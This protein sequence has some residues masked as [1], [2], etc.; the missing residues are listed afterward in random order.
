[1]SN[2]LPSKTGLPNSIYIWFSS[3]KG[4]QHGPRIKVSN[5]RGKFSQS[6]DFSVSVSSNPKVVAGSPDNF[7]I[8][9]INLIFDWVILNK[10][11][12]LD[13][14]KSEIITDDDVKEKV[15]KV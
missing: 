6:S 13:Y 3:G 5:V 15:Q 2:L 4:A 8:K 12:L 7:T 9:E 14:W 10:N 11:L 1:M